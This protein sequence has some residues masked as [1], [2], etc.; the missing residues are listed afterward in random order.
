MRTR[1]VFCVTPVA[2]DASFR[3]RSSMLS[4][5]LICM[6]M[7]DRCRLRQCAAR[8]RPHR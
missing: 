8:G 5:V 3:S 2:R 6:T 1:D 4:V 7:P